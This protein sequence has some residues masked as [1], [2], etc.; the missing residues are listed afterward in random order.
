VTRGAPARAFGLCLLTLTLTG[1]AARGFVP[2]SGAPVPFPEG[3]DVWTGLTQTCRDVSG[4]RAQLRVSGRVNGARV[5]GLTAGVALEGPR[6]ALETRYGG[7]RLFTIA[8]EASDAVLL[9]HREARFVR[10]PA[11]DVVDALVGLRLE[12]AR[13]LALLTGCITGSDVSRADR[14]GALARLTASDAVIY[15]RQQAGAWRLRAA[16]LDGLMVDFRRVEDG[17]PRQMMIRRAADVSV[18]VEVIEF[19]DNPPL[20]PGL[21]RATVPEPFVEMSLGDLRDNGPFGDRRD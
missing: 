13:L 6:I 2:P 7:T 8:G 19:E 5:P 17:W 16:E 10:G 21:F 4:Y 15:L 18:T 1:C 3:T 12:P 9:L 20:V 14:I 11:A